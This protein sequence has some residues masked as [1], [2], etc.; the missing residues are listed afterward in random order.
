[1]RRTSRSSSKPKGE[2]M[3]PTRVLTAVDG[4]ETAEH[5]AREASRLCQRTGSELHVVHVAPPPYI[6]AG[7]E[8]FAWQ[9][10]AEAYVEELERRTEAGG[11]ELL[12]EQIEKIEASG[13]QVT[14]SHLELGQVDACVV[15]LAEEL[16]AGLLVVGNR[17]Y[18]AVRRTLMGSVSTSLIHHAHCP[19]LVVRGTEDQRSGLGTGAIVVAYDGSESSE[20]AAGA[21]AELAEALNAELHLATVVH[22]SRVIPYPHPYAQVGWEKEIKSAE[23]EARDFLE[24]AASRLEAASGARTTL[25]VCTG[26]P[27]AEIVHLGDK[28]G[29]SLTLVGSR[30]LGGIK[31]ALLGSVSTS[32][33][34]HALG[35]VLVFRPAEKA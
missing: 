3:F 2:P 26:Q 9:A 15:N 6:W 16:D 18:S 23:Q 29:A 22:M 5:A 7:T 17:G 19:V 24:K 20:R 31:R 1:L 11:R 27:S 12:T 21:G 10:E 4:S 34:H 14:Q 30:G 33:V 28:L 25:H 13:A 35:S 32:V 8:S